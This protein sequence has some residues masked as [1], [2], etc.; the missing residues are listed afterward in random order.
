MSGRFLV[1]AYGTIGIA[2]ASLAA[3][4]TGQELPRAEQI[5]T[6][7]LFR[8][9]KY[10]EG[11]CFDHEGRGYISWGKAITRLTCRPWKREPPITSSR[12]RLAVRSSSAVFAMQFSALGQSKNT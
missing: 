2:L 1:L 11:V 4:V 6:V 3:L 12:A 8:V 5:K 10:C 9:P 7:E